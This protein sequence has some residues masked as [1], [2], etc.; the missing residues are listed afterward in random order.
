MLQWIIH[1]LQ[2]NPVS[3]S[4]IWAGVQWLSRVLLMLS[5]VRSTYEHLSTRSTCNSD[6]LKN[7]YYIHTPHY[8]LNGHCI[9]VA[10]S[11]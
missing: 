11:P 2:L 4:P 7:P 3:S 9:M 1:D 6:A 5:V 10:H 8:Y